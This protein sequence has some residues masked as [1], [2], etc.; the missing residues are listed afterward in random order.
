[1]NDQLEN[2]REEYLIILEEEYKNENEMQLLQEDNVI[3]I[4]R[5]NEKDM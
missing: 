2:E 3:Y 4:A 1:M 5:L